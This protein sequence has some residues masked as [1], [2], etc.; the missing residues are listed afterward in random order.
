MKKENEISADCLKKY[1][2]K[3]IKN[4]KSISKTQ[5]KVKNERHSVFTEKI[6]K[7]ALTYKTNAHGMKKDLVNEQEEINWINV[8]NHQ[9]DIDRIYLSRKDPFKEKDQLLISK[10]ETI[11]LQH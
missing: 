11:G 7:A 9:P 3:F 6:N 10:R 5:Q 1:D 8:I 4:N 2:K